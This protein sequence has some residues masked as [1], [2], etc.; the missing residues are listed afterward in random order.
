MKEMINSHPAASETS[1][2]AGNQQGLNLGSEEV[3]PSELEL[4]SGG[5]RM[6]MLASGT[7]VYRGF[8]PAAIGYD[9]A[10]TGTCHYP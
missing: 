3:T 2:T 4:V 7:V 10:S 9:D 5:F 6:Q 8:G 1:Y